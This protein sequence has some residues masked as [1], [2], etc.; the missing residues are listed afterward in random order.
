MFEELAR[1][2]YS[3][4]QMKK[5]AGLN[6]LRVMRKAEATA[7]R[8]RRERPAALLTSMNYVNASRRWWTIWLAKIRP[9]ISG[10]LNGSECRL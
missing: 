5:L 9:G 3:D 2:G 8:L 10:R 4:E 1:R 7:A 6:V